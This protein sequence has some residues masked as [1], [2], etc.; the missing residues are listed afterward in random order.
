MS[1]SSPPETSTKRRRM[2][3]SFSLFSAPPIGT[4]QPRAPPSAT[5]LGHIE[6]AYSSR[7]ILT[8]FERTAT[9]ASS[10]LDVNLTA[11]DHGVGPLLL[12]EH[13]QVRIIA[14]GERALASKPEQFGGICR[15][16]GQHD[17]ERQPASQC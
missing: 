14:G 11:H 9:D 15:K 2:R 7:V 3:R 8:L 12:V 13:D 1:A 17:F 5:L 10:I 6:W 16:H 4:I